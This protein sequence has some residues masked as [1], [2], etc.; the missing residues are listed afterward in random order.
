MTYHT[1][2]PGGRVITAW[3]KC[4]CGHDKDAHGILGRCFS[5]EWIHPR[6]GDAHRDA[7]T[8]QPLYGFEAAS[9][10]CSI[11]ERPTTH[12]DGIHRDC[13]PVFLREPRG[14]AP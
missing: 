7:A 10:P 4:R 9:Q 8:D 6:E 2:P 14:N 13:T 3:P 12:P 11:C 1:P 5:C